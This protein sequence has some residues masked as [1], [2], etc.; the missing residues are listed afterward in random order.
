MV[1]DVPGADEPGI[2]T[3]MLLVD[4][5]IEDEDKV[6]KVWRRTAFWNHIECLK[7]F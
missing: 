1:M 2:F 5:L 6:S 3:F 4:K 7:L